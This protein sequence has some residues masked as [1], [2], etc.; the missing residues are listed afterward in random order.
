MT[1]LTTLLTRDDVARLLGLSMREL[2]WWIWALRESRRY[3]EFEIDRR[4]GGKPRLIQTPI[5]PIRDMQ[6]T[7]RPMLDE[8][9][10]P[11]PHVHG[12]VEGRSAVTNATVH[13]R[14][15]WILRI[16]IKDF[17]PSINFGRVRGM[18]MAY[19]FDLPEDV[20]T[21][22]AQICCYKGGLPQGAPTSP[23]IS[24]LICRGLDKQLAHFARSA[25]CSYSRYA[26]DMCFSTGRRDFPRV[27]AE[28]VERRPVLNP[29]LRGIVSDSGFAINEEKTRLMP[30][31]Q[32]QRV[33]GLVVNH[34]VNVPREYYRHL[35]AVLHIWRK[36]GQEE[37][38]A[39]F[40]R[41]RPMPNW[42]PEKASA[43]F[44]LVVRG[45]LQYFGHTRRYDR[46][47]QVLAQILAACD[48]RFT[49]TLPKVPVPGQVTFAGEG[50]SDAPHLRAAQH[51]L[52]PDFAGL[53]LV[54]V[55]HQPPKNDEALWKWLNAIKDS[56]NAVPRIGIFDCDSKFADQFG[57]DGWEH[58]GNGV[59]AVVIARPAWID[60]GDR[61]CMEML[62]RPETLGLVNKDGR[63]IFLRAEFAEDGTSHDGGYAM[64]FPQKTTLV[65]EDVDR[66]SD[67]ESV[68]LSKTAF[69]AAVEGGVAPYGTI[70]FEGFRPTFERL[71]QAVA[72]AQTACR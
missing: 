33:T 23:V 30:R 1:E 21:V 9:Y 25:H 55:S 31:Y 72:A 70:D 15:R 5:K 16:D 7:L 65:V 59:A 58:L 29:D 43:E 6:E 26:D 49:P 19:P 4:S 66:L 20:A 44:R 40:A 27:L 46:R 36:Y 47:Y 45:Q 61:F 32:R 34:E 71:A 24:N 38:E 10:E 67:G 64:R 14:Q 60:E 51:A 69:A 12:F 57:R 35:R 3:H 68:G 54:E 42:P 17:F 11:W 18:F 22:L 41:A 56:Q 62:H 50:P 53:H 13:R 2:T 8:V 28:V 37:A 39:A 63:R 52:R 48:P